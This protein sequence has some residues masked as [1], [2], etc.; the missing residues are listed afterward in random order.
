MHIKTFLINF[1]STMSA[2]SNKQVSRTPKSFAHFKNASEN[3][4]CTFFDYSLIKV[5][6]RKWYRNL[7]TFFIVSLITINKIYSPGLFSSLT[8]VTSSLKRASFCARFE[9][10]RR[11]FHSHFFS[12]LA[13][14]QS[15]PAKI[16]TSL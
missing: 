4:M 1:S 8:Y 6:N 9:S 16:V 14:A 7:L 13:Y 3:K 10:Q 2:V 5:H 11:T 15:Q 12:F